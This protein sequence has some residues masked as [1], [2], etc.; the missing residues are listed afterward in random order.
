MISL[1]GF[2]FIDLRLCPRKT[3]K[4]A[5]IAKGRESDKTDLFLAATLASP[6]IWRRNL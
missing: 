5:N 2:R 3:D 4:T 1:F 6:T